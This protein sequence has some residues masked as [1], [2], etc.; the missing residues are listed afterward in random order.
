LKLRRR[1]GEGADDGISF[2]LFGNEWKWT[3]Y[4]TLNTEN[5]FEDIIEV[6]E[7]PVKSA[8]TTKKK[9]A[10]TK[11]KT[12]KPL[13]EEVEEDKLADETV[14]GEVKAAKTKSV[15]PQDKTATKAKISKKTVGWGLVTLAIL[16]LVFYTILESKDKLND[17]YNKFRNRNG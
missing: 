12:V 10:A 2:S 14:Q 7:K 8:S 1:C 15:E 11:K 4:Q 5:I 13:A 3:K 9:V 6:E 17:F 16:G